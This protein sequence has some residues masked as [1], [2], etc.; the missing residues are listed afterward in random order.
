L[1]KD[2]PE[3][4]QQLKSGEKTISEAKKE[5][6]KEAVMRKVEDYKQSMAS[7]NDFEIDINTTDKKFNII[8]ADPP[9]IVPGNRG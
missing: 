6:K 4:F 1:K 8:Y 9:W 3:R 7:N 2:S 5:E